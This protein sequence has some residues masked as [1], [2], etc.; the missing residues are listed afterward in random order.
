MFEFDESFTLELRFDPSALEL[1][2]DVILSPNT[3]T[4]DII[5]NEGI[6]TIPIS[7]KVYA[8]IL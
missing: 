4:V 8:T 1:P 3:T 6:K 5:D 2:S 7:L